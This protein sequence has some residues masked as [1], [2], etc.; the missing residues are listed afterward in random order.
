M[1]FQKNWMKIGG[2]LPK[3]L[4]KFPCFSVNYFLSKIRGFASDFPVYWPM[5]K[6]D[7]EFL[8]LKKARK[9]T[10]FVGTWSSFWVKMI[11]LCLLHCVTFGHSLVNRL[12]FLLLELDLC[13]FLCPDCITVLGGWKTIDKCCISLYLRYLS[14]K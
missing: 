6:S 10:I 5:R 12:F 4:Q 3:I 14:K 11:V 2:I 1:C 7:W 13:S 8:K 9:V